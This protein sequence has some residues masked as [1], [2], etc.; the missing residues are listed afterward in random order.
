M[1]GLLRWGQVLGTGSGMPREPWDPSRGGTNDKR[2]EPLCRE[3]SCQ[4]AFLPRVASAQILHG[5]EGVDGSSPSEGLKNS[6]Q[7]GNFRALSLPIQT[8]EG[9][10]REH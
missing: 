3:R 2:N 8:R 4:A 6:L 5:K 7:I 10:L 9:P 1:I